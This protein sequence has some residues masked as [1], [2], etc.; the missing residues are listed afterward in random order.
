VLI[1]TAKVYDKKHTY[2]HAGKSYL[3]SNIA[4][5]R[6]HRH[7]QL[8]HFSVLTTP[9]TNWDLCKKRKALVIMISSETGRRL[10]GLTT[11]LASSRRTSDKLQRIL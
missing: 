10:R 11:D 2:T 7:T 4:H 6:Y 9:Q 5:Q 3:L 1:N 8:A